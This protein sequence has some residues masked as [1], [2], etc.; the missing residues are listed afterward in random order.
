MAPVGD[1]GVTNRPPGWRIAWAPVERRRLAWRSVQ[2]TRS[3]V[4]GKVTTPKNHQRRRVDLSPQLR[5]ELRR[6][7]K[8]QSAAWLARGRPRPAWVF[9]SSTGTPLDESKARKAFNQILDKAELHRRGPHQMRHTF[10]SLL[11]QAGGA[12]HLRES[13]ARASGCVDYASRVCSLAAGRHSGA[14]CRPT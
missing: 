5:V 11:L 7:R 10:A 6:W 3:I 12:N 2:I 9:P 8:Q 1:H 13:A 14:R 4:R